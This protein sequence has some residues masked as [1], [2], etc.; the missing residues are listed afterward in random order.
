MFPVDRLERHDQHQWTDE[1]LFDEVLILVE[2]KNRPYYDE[3]R[4][5]QISRALG[6]V[7]FEQMMRYREA[8]PDDISELQ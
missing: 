2:M 5:A 7:T 1:Q 6:R 4:K 3:E 8:H